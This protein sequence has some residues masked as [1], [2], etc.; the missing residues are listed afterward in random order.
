MS[1]Y[2][3]ICDTYPGIGSGTGN[4]SGVRVAQPV[5][6][7]PHAATGGA[8]NWLM[9]RG[10]Q[11][12]VMGPHSWV[13]YEARTFSFWVW[14]DDIHGDYIWWIGLSCRDALYRSVSMTGTITIVG[15][16]A[17][18]D[19]V[20]PF[21]TPSDGSVYTVRLQQ[22]TT[23]SNTP[24]ELQCTISPDG[25]FADIETDDDYQYIIVHGVHIQEASQVFLDGRGVATST[26]EARQPIF[27]DT[28][29]PPDKSITAIVE[30]TR[31]AQDNYVRRGELFTWWDPAGLFS[32]TTSGSYVDVFICRPAIQRRLIS[33][34]QTVG[35]IKARVCC[36]V[37]GGSGQVKLSLT[38]GATYTWA[39]TDTANNWQSEQTLECETDDPDRW[40]TDGGIRGGTRDE[41]RLEVKAP[42]GQTLY[43]VGLSICETPTSGGESESAN[44]LMFE[45]NP[46]TYGGEYIFVPVPYP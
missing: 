14:P 8:I 38:S 41:V 23:A 17:E 5:I 9:G 46:V 34:G 28:G 19:L 2:R 13:T 21:T 10:H 22:L 1:L 44:V 29:D 43:I 24:L 27:W 45:G 15:I 36:R 30:T 11:L 12:A 20:V 42:V 31:Y 32:S 4:Q 16:G 6:G 40:P 33:L 18:P 39:V 7:R 3:E 35:D 25:S 26:L 37:T